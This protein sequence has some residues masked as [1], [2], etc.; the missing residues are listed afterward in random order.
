[1]KENA[2]ETPKRIVT[3]V[4]ERPK[5]YEELS[6]EE[7]AASDRRTAKYREEKRLARLAEQQR[8][9]LPASDIS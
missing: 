1:M 2:A 5:R 4:R 3:V 8:N 9:E 7:K 6:P